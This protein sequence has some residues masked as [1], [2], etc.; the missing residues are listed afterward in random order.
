MEL[1]AEEIDLEQ[2]GLD[3]ACLTLRR[4]G[5]SALHRFWASRA[6]CLNHGY[7]ASDKGPLFLLEKGVVVTPRLISAT[8]CLTRRTNIADR[9]M[10]TSHAD[11]R[12]TFATMLA[13]MGIAHRS[14]C[15]D[16]RSWSR[17]AKTPARSCAIMCTATCL[18]GRRMRS[19]R[20]TSG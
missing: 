15:C 16:R 6:R 7:P 9:R 20:G 11:L 13:E 1:R 2:V 14:G 4:M 8:I 18:S 10:I 3:A 5:G 12:R 17:A 19:R